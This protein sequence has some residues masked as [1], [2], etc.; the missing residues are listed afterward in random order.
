MA[1]SANAD[2]I[3]RQGFCNFRRLY[4]ARCNRLH[5]TLAQAGAQRILQAG[6][7]RGEELFT[8]R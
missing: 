3:V 6:F 2:S 8:A 1:G 7:V 4:S 5:D